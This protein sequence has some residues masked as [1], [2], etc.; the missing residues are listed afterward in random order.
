MTEGMESP[1]V[2]ARFEQ[3]RKDPKIVDLREKMKRGERVTACCD[4]HKDIV[5]VSLDPDMPQPNEQLLNALDEA[6]TC[7]DCRLIMA[8]VQD[9]IEYLLGGEKKYIA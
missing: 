7:K 1:L 9:D 4:K 8:A 6:A 5:E 3:L 2:L